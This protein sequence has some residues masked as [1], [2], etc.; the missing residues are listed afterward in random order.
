MSYLFM[1]RSIEGLQTMS[2]HRSWIEIDL[3]Q[4]R[5]NMG[6]IKGYIH[7]AKYCLPIKSNAY[8]HGLV[9]IGKIAEQEKVDYLAV[10][11]LSE[12]IILRKEGITLPILIFGAFQKEEIEECVHYNLEL[13]IS[14][15]YK[16][17]LVEE[18]LKSMQQK[19]KV[20]LK[21]DTG[22]RR[23]GARPKTALEIYHRIK[24]SSSMLLKGIYSHLANADEHGHPYNQLQINAFKSFLE[25]ID[26]KGILCHFSNSSRILE[27]KLRFENMLRIGLLTFGIKRGAAIP[28]IKDI[29]N[30]F[31]LKSRV[32]Y[33]KVIEEG[34]GVSYG[35][36]FITKK[37]TRIATIPIGYGDGYLR[38][39]SNKGCVI[40]R[41][42]KYPIVGTICMD[43]LMVDIG[44][45]EAYVGDEVVLIGKQGA[46]EITIEEI[47][48]KAVW[49]MGLLGIVSFINLFIIIKDISFAK[50]IS[51]I[52]LIISLGTFGFFAKVGSTGGEIRHSEIR[53]NN[54]DNNNGIFNSNEN[55]NH[56]DADDD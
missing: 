3:N 51:V 5:K 28:W 14:S 48:E 34:E 17:S 2:S 11:S 50:T 16:A 44:E 22:M 55:R 56:D 37:R 19:A 27:G 41:E 4:L 12:G 52:T 43:Q 10:A 31:S 6:I 35:H 1:D 33:F 15:E 23:I 8:G 13:T 24:K 30:S 53:A 36:T 7:P 18:A 39:L 38:A 42:K 49:L 21:I 25:Q 26:S 20:H 54:V 32:S 45:G 40:I 47:A 46:H 29:K 9:Q